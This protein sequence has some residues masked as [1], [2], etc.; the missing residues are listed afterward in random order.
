MKTTARHSSSR[1]PAA[2]PTPR[3]LHPLALALS[4]VLLTACAAVGPD[5]REP[6]PVDIGAGSAPCH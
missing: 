6:P 1:T 5:Y 3:R 2:E 4:C